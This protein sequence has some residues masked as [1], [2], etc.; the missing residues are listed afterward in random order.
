M[1]CPQLISALQKQ[2]SLTKAQF[3]TLMRQ[4]LIGVAVGA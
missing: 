1:Q 4:Q 3:T 2:G